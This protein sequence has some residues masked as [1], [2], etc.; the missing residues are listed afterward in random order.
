MSVAMEAKADGA[1]VHLQG[2]V[3]IEEAAELASLLRQALA[4]A[5]Q[6]VVETGALEGMD[7][8][9]LQVLCAAHRQAMAQGCAMRLE[10]RE[11]QALRTAAE[12]AG[13]L[14]TACMEHPCLYKHQDQ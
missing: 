14:G 4:G 10:P 7:L 5:Q 6:L 8:A 1:V 12:R 3:G 2:Q 13:Y 11:A 9:T